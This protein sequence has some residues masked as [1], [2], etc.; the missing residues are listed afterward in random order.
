VRP[1]LIGEQMRH[2]ACEIGAFSGEI[3]AVTTVSFRVD[4]AGG[5]FVWVAVSGDPPPTLRW[6]RTGDAVSVDRAGGAFVWRGI[7]V[8]VRSPSARGSV[9]VNLSRAGVAAGSQAVS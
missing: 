5:G 8:G 1:G 2:R 6:M 3:G 4:L 9:S 7:A